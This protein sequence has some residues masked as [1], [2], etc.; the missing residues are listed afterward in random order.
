M[1]RAVILTGHFPDQ[2]RRGSILWLADGMQALGWHVTLVTVGYSRLSVMLRDRRLC[3]LDAAPRAGLH[4]HS[5]SLSSLFS[6]S[7]VHPM[8][9]LESASPFFAGAF[10]RHWAAL[11]PKVVAGADRVIVES[12][13][14]VLLAP[15]VRASAPKAVVIYRANDD[16]R[17][18]RQSRCV[19]RAEMAYQHLFD[20]ISTG[21]AELAVRFD[22]PHVTIDPMGVPRSR[23]LHLLP[24]PYGAREGFET[25][26][27]GTTQLDRT[28]LCR[29][30]T[31]RPHW[32]LHVLGRVRMGRDAVPSNIVFHDE[33]P[34]D[35]TLAFV[36][37]ADIG[38]APY[39]DAPGV[40]YQRTNSNRMLLYRHF[41][42]PILGPDRLCHPTVPSIIGYGDPQIWQR[43][44]TKMRQ[45]EVL[46]DWSELADR[47][48]A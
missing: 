9:A 24:S 22:H 17:L 8:G 14:P 10:V 41:G 3:A 35:T 19:L 32:R 15:V 18:L 23:L 7:A 44:E 11:L 40:E 33:Q 47:L 6:L 42:L 39:I 30:A 46:P 34:F 31:L 45:P 28:A 13:L 36:A 37:H 16:L 25:V 43:C 21:S 4:R 2:K 5:D 29:I 20:R 12:G 27:A 26:C 1:K 38:L 48:V